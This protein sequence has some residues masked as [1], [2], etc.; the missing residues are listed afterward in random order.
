M[1]H[2]AFSVSFATFRQ[3]VTRL[4]ARGIKHSGPKDRGFMDSVYFK[5][6]C[7]SLVELACYKFEQPMGRDLLPSNH[8]ATV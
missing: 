6:P 7:G 1:P 8:A 3:V 5:D 2:V 4:D